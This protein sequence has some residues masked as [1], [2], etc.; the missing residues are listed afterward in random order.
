MMSRCKRQGR[1]LGQELSGQPCEVISRESPVEGR[2]HGFVVV[3]EA[4]QAIFD[5]S[6]AGEVV[7]SE[8]L[9][10]DDGEVDLNLVEPT[11]VNRA[12]N[13]EQVGKGLGQASHAGRAPMRGAVIHD[14]EHA[15]CVTIGWLSHD[16]SNETAERIDAGGFLATA[17]NLGT[18]YIERRQVGPSS[19]ALIFVFDASGTLGAR[20][21]GGMF[22][23]ARLDAGFLV[24][25]EH[26]L[27]PAQAFALPLLG[28]QIENAPGL[29]CEIRI[30]REDPGAVLPGPNGV[31]V[32]P[33]PHGGVTDARNDAA[34]LRF[35]HDIG[36]T[37][38][39]Q[40][41]PTRGRQFTGDGLDLHH[42]LWGGRPGGDPGVGA[43]R[44][45]VV[46]HERTACAI[47]LQH[48]GRP[49]ARWRSRRW[50]DPR[51]QAGSSWRGEP[52]NMATYTC[53]PGFPESRVPSAR[54]EL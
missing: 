53:V 30:A 1:G 27:V 6:E 49:R 54:A 14:P 20:W 17:K 25:A 5:L 31:L 38:T 2:G 29:E 47:G 19:T 3:L 48:R 37:E 32:Q 43:L 33:A 16:L 12:V 46:V 36:T 23:H 28:V 22:A 26:E 7:G 9:A 39:R 24:G 42:Q 8:C 51:R 44:V 11:G 40:R 10:L 41:Q 18:V 35:A 13:R 52:R 45:P 4:Q 15:P 21:R 34:L 50:H